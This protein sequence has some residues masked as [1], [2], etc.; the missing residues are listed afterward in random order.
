MRVALDN[1]FIDIRGT[2]QARLPR[3]MFKAQCKLFY[4]Q[5][6]SQQP[7]EIPEEKRTT[8]FSNKWYEIGCVITSAYEN[9]TNV[10]K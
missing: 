5:W 1:W 6:L 3:T 9:R 4:D 7:D 8:V 2:L 10:S